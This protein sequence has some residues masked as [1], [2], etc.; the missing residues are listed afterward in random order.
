MSALTP[1]DPF[2]ELDELQNRLATMFGRIPQRQ[3]ARTG[4][5]AMTTADWAPM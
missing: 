1:W 4:N 3:G 2:R 5:E